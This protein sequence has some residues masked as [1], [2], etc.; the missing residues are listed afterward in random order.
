MELLAAGLFLT[1]KKVH[2]FDFMNSKPVA[3]KREKN[4]MRESSDDGCGDGWGTRGVM[5]CVAETMDNM[6]PF[7]Y[8]ACIVELPL[9]MA[10]LAADCAYTDCPAG[11]V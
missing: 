10:V 1:G 7:S 11:G 4:G 5:E 3:Y 9:C 2:S 8:G 6:G